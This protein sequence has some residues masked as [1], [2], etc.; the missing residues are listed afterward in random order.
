VLQIRD[1]ETGSLIIEQEGVVD[2][3]SIFVSRDGHRYTYS[4]TRCSNPNYVYNCYDQPT[5]IGI[6]QGVLSGGEVRELAR[7][8]VNAE[9]AAE[10]VGSGAFAPDASAFMYSLAGEIYSV[11]LTE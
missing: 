9:I 8:L 10:S 5:M 3:L 2:G 1:L 4:S 6:I 11:S 7:H